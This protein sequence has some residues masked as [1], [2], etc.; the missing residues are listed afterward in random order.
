MSAV[1]PPVP[2]QENPVTVAIDNTTVLLVVCV[3]EI[4]L[5]PKLIALVTAPVELNIPVLKL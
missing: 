1:K 4:L 2:V 5:E 3:N